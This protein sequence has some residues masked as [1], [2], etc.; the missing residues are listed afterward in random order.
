MELNIKRGGI[1][2]MLAMLLGAGVVQAIFG[3]QN[4]VLFLLVWI[5]TVIDELKK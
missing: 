2:S 3:W 5:G 1:L 4:A